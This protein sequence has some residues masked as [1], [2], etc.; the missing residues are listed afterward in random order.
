ML[1]P[2]P[3]LLFLG[4][5]APTVLRI[6]A[7]LVFL[8]LTRTHWNTRGHVSENLPAFVRRFG[9]SYA[10][11]LIAV[12]MLV[13][14]ALIVGFLTQVAALVGFLGAVKAGL[15]R[16]RYPLSFPLSGTTYFLLC[17]ILLVLI[18]TGAGAF[19]I[20]LPL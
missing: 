6:A 14:I 5:V 9:T 20:D 4:I 12:E 10:F 2:F 16:R 8:G 19:A 18:F 13:G 15:L 17:S 1:N 7:G 3:E 11:A